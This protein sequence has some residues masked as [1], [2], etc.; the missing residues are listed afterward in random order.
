MMKLF[1]IKFL[2]VF[3]YNQSLCLTNLWGNVGTIDCYLMNKNSH[4][5]IDSLTM[6]LVKY[7][8]TLSAIKRLSI[9]S[10]MM[11]PA[12]T[13]LTT[14]DFSHLSNSVWWYNFVAL[15][16]TCENVYSK[17]TGKR[18]ISG[19]FIYVFWD[20]L[21]AHHWVSFFWIKFGSEI[22]LTNNFGRSDAMSVSWP[23]FSETELYFLPLRISALGKC[24]SN[25]ERCP[26]GQELKLPADSCH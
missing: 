1:H 26:Q 14:I 10:G 17:E 6:W 20:N 19:S 3:N 25:Q 15:I 13:R 7:G 22:S 21:P 23:S 16:L 11:G 9:Q 2:S 24:P 8:D 5:F 12:C 4:N 18:Y